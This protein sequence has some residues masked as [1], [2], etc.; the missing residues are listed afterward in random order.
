MRTDFPGFRF[1]QFL[2]NLGV[3]R[4]RSDRRFTESRPQTATS[5]QHQTAHGKSADD[6]I[7]IAGRNHDEH[8]NLSCGLDA[9]EPNRKRLF[10]LL[11]LRHG[12]GNGF[13]HFGVVLNDF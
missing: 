8:H 13:R 2:L 12:C 1:R 5:R 9:Q 4:I 7:W 11:W 6:H 10:L 3:P